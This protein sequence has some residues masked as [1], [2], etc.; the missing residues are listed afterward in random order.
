MNITSMN[1]ITAFR[2][3]HEAIEI[4]IAE[5]ESKGIESDALQLASSFCVLEYSEKHG[6]SKIILKQN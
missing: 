1:N 4:L 6:L 3:A 2:K 5:L